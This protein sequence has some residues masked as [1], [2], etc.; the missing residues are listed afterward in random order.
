[1]LRAAAVGGSAVTLI[2]PTA[3][4]VLNTT[5]LS[6]GRSPAV[7]EPLSCEFIEVFA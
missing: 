7:T 6:F 3:L 5:Q 4:F 1:M 2:K